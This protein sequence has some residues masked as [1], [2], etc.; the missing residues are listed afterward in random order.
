VTRFVANIE[1]GKRT[2]VVCLFDLKASG[3]EAEPCAR[4][5]HVFHSPDD[6]GDE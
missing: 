6:A 3:R 4:S 2:E 1:P 5:L